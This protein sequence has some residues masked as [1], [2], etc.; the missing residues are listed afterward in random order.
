MKVWSFY[1]PTDGLFTGQIIAGGRSALRDNLP[2]ELEAME[3]RFDHRRYRIDLATGKVIDYKPPAPSSEHE[4]D[5]TEKIWVLSPKEAQRIAAA[6]AIRQL[7]QKQQ[8]PLRE[9]ALTP[10]DAE[11]RR[12]VEDIDREIAEQRLA[13]LRS[14]LSV[15]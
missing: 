3:G 10:D 1:D 6:E 13:A 11:A 7:E 14:K 9:L 2:D 8:R 15:S 4:W 12:R 5:E